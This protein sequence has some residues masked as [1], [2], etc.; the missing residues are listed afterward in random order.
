MGYGRIPFDV[1]DTLLL[2]RLFK[3]GDITFSQVG[4]SN[5]NGTF[6]DLMPYR[7]MASFPSTSEYRLAQDEVAAWETLARE[8]KACDAWNSVWFTAARKFFLYG[9]AKELS[10]ERGE[11]DRIVDFMT[12]LEA[13][14]V[15]ENDFVGRRLRDRAAALLGNN[16]QT[17]GQPKGCLETSTA[18]DQLSYMGAASQMST[19]EIFNVGLSSNQLFDKF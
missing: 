2:L 8:L 18:S 17:L 15:P 9:A 19:A 11:V 7:A 5:P 1:E 16:G 4:I 14:L 10:V 13:S 3:P 12:A 6:A